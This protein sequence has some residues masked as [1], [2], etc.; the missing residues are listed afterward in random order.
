MKALSNL[1]AKVEQGSFIKGFEIDIKG[2]GE[3]TQV[4]H[5]LFA[6]DTFIFFVRIKY[7]S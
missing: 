6:N 1:I 2:P 4:S 3:T 5:Q 7:I